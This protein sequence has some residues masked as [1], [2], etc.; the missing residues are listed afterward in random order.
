MCFTTLFGR[1]LPDCFMAQFTVFIKVTS[2]V[3]RC[4]QN[5]MSDARSHHWELPALCRL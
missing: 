5:K 2:R 1:L 3:Y 4:P